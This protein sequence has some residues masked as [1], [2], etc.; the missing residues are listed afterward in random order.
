MITGNAD[1]EYGNVNGGEILTVTKAGTNK[2][3]GS[4]YAFYENQDGTANTW[5]TT[6]TK[7]PR[8]SST[9]TCSAAPSAVPCSG[10]SC[11]SSRTM[12]ASAR[13]RPEPASS[14]CLRAECARA[15][16]LSSWAHRTHLR[17]VHSCGA[18]HPAVQH[19]ATASRQRTPYVN[20]QLPVINPVAQYIFA[21]PEFYPLPNRPSTN[22]N[23]PDTNNYGGY[24]KSAVVNNQ[25]D[26]RVDYVASSARTTFR[27]ASRMVVP[28]ISPS[29]PFLPS[30]FR[31]VMTIRSGTASSTKYIPSA[32]TC[33]TSS[34]PATRV[35][36]ISAAFRPIRFGNFPTG[37][38]TKVGYPYASPYPGFTE[39]NISSAEKNIG[40]LGVVQNYIDNIFD[41]GDTVTWLH[42]KHII[43]AGAQILRYQENYYYASNNGNMGQFAYNGDIH[44]GSNGSHDSAKATALRTLSSMLPSSRLLPV[45][46]DVIGQR[47]YRM[48]F[49]GEDQ[50]K[51]TPKL[52][53]NLG[54]R[55]GY[56]QP[57]YEVNNKEVNVD[58]KNPQ[59]CPNCLLVAGKNGASSALYNPFH[60]QFMPRVSFAY[61]MNPQM[62]IRGGYGITDDFEGM[63]AAQRLTQNPPFIPQYSVHQ[64][65]AFGDERW[66]THP[67]QPG[68]QR[69]WTYSWWLRTSTR[70]GTRTSSPS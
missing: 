13:P 30:S 23:S 20:D 69:W 8:A 28:T 10:T 32:R 2:F 54:L 25:G 27:L 50:W 37:S 1:A 60:T 24:N 49:F 48:A 17:S 31:V 40:T 42:G 53:L 51:V 3:H 66:N 34:A 68:L 33:R 12:R 35:S 22:A 6:T 44:Q 16:S 9:R 56:D 5:A 43:K 46:Q 61:Q 39:S 62:V 47:Q 19:H 14:R 64:H 36:V 52:T 38:D 58:V 55:Y 7:L 41:Y 65:G 11:S 4:L 15:I 59:N 26:I 70:P 67:C 18:I 63:G 29:C 21:H 57:M 45:R